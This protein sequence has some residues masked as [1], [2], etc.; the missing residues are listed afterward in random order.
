M[1]FQT[2]TYAKKKRKLIVGNEKFVYNEGDENEE[3]EK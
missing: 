2:R 1:Q 3:N